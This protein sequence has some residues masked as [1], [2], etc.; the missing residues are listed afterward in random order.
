V[1][2]SDNIRQLESLASADLVPQATV[3][4]LTGAYR[5]Y[6]QRMHHLALESADN[7]VVSADEF[8]DTRAAVTAIWDATMGET[9]ASA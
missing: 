8:R 5:A 3:D 7:V 6:R 9:S 1:T 4:V 2:Y